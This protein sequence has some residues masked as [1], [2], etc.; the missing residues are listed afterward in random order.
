[1][2]HLGRSSYGRWGTCDAVGLSRQRRASISA[3]VALLTDSAAFIFDLR[4]AAAGR[5]AFSLSVGIGGDPLGS[6]PRWNHPLHAREALDL[7]AA[8]LP[9]PAWFSA[10]VKGAETGVDGA[11]IGFGAQFL[12][13]RWGGEGTLCKGI[14]DQVTSV[15]EKS[16]HSVEG[17]EVR[18]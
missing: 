13:R 6:P 17:K 7:K 16:Q 12:D 2:V 5:V 4:I 11:L 8:P 1:V 9:L 10:A 15:D 14:V 18:V 3:T